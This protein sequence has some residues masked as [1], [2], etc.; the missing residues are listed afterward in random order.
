MCWKKCG[1]KKE[2]MEQKKSIYIERVQGE[3]NE[4]REFNR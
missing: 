2:E 3:Q 1:K 4:T